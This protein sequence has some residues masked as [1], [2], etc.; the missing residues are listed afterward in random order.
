MSVRHRDVNAL[1]LHVVFTECLAQSKAVL[2]T[3]A[4]MPKCANVIDDLL[5][6]K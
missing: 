1:P 4:E 5:S 3:L 2:D 6:A